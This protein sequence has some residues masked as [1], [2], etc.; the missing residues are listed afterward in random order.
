MRVV[1][2][3]DICV[4]GVAHTVPCDKLV[5]VVCKNLLP[6][7]G[8]AIIIS[9]AK[10]VSVVCKNPI[11]L[12]SATL[13]IFRHKLVSVVSENHFALNG[14]N[15]WHQFLA[16]M[17]IYPPGAVGRVIIVISIRVGTAGLQPGWTAGCIR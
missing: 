3:N 14:V 17:G 13:I 15:K 2:K 10:L 6:F 12:D 5:S 9:C 1:S 4:N 8:V 16:R 7:N 11:S